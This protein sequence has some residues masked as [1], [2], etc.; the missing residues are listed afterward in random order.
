[1]TVVKE[2]LALKV[3]RSSF[4]D[5]RQGARRLKTRSGR[6]RLVAIAQSSRNAT[7]RCLV[8][9]SSKPRASSVE[10]IAKTDAAGEKAY[11]AYLRHKESD[12][13]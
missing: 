1:M 9:A 7:I 8:C 5:G 10:I 12:L 3:T 2:N 11:T 6:V 13:S 4:G